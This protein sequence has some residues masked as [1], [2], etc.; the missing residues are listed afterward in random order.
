MNEQGLIIGVPKEILSGENRVA[1][2][3]ETVRKLAAK[4]A[5]VL[6]EKGAGEGS[7][8][9]DA[10]YREAGAEIVEDVEDIYLRSALILKVKEPKFNAAKGCHEVDMMHRGQYLVTF[11][12]PAS[13][14][15][16][17]MVKKLAG[18]GVI[19]LTLDS[20]PRISRAQSMD[21]LTSM[22]TV[23]GYKGVLMAANLL[24]KFIPMMGVAAGMIKPA[25]VLV[26]GTG[27]A[28]L[29][30]IATAKRLGA[31]VSGADI[32]QDAC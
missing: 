32:R 6:I 7:H 21:A 17:E 12:H 3:P 18:Q 19:S 16:Y 29:Q 10:S 11:L 27:V 13:P 15:N 9:N 2:I 20:I 25:R 14:G 30:A 4:G 24:P 23:A 8:Y 5:S 28:G 1:A 26:V 31:V 22:S